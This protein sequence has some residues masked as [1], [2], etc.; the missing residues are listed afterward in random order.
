MYQAASMT[1]EPLCLRPDMSLLEARD[2]FPGKNFRHFP[3]TGAGGHLL[4][5]VTVRRRPEVPPS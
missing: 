4:G 2:S 5:R 1:R 3:V